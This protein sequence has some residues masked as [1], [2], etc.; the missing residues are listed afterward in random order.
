MKDAHD[1][2]ICRLTLG[3]TM[4]IWLC[5]ACRA[6]RK[7]AGWTVEITKTTVL[8][9]LDCDDCNYRTQEAIP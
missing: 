7:A 3:I 8:H 5:T 4:H 9:K 1:V 6:L 2:V